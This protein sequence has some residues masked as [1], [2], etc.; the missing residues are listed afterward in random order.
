MIN[1]IDIPVTIIPPDQQAVE[2]SIFA[3]V[4]LPSVEE[5]EVRITRH[6]AC[7]DQPPLLFVTVG[8]VLAYM[9]RYCPYGEL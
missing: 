9:E 8:A 5:G 2:E 3:T 7:S 1:E 4:S 6:A